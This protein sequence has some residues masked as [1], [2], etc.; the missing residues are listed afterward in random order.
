MSEL[1]KVLLDRAK[2]LR[3]ADVSELGMPKRALFQLFFSDM[4]NLCEQAAAALQTQPSGG[5]AM[6]SNMCRQRELARSVVF[7]PLVVSLPPSCSYPA[8]DERPINSPYF[9]R[10]H[11]GFN[12][13]I[14]IL[15]W[16]ACRIKKVM[17]PSGLK[18]PSFHQPVR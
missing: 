4:A 2:A 5:T 9:F 6:P 16:S 3:E 10:F 14:R 15:P 13:L 1:A 12:R 8:V 17:Q 18:S 7:P 11:P